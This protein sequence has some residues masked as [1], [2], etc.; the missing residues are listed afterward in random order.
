MA[1]SGCMEDVTRCMRGE[2]PRR[3]PVFCCTEEADVRLSGEVYERYCS[4]AETM[5]R[6]Q[7]EAIKRF[8]LDW[9]WLQVDDCI[10]YEVLGVGVVGQGNILRATKDYLP[11]SRETLNRLKKIDFHKD[12]RCPVLLNAIRRV[13]DEFGDDVCVVGRTEAPLSS[14]S[15]L[16]GITETMMLLITD[17]Q[18]VKD[19]MEYFVDLQIG[20]GLAQFEAGADALWFGDC[21]ASSHLI[22]LNHYQEFAADPLKKV[23]EEYAKTGKFTILH[24]SE[25]SPEY[26]NVMAD[27]SCSAVSVGPGAPLAECYDVIAGRAC[28]VGNVDPIEVLYRGTP[29]DVRKQTAEIIETVSRRGG[30]IINSGEMVPRDTPEENVHAMVQTARELWAQA[31]SG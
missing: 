10:I 26:V 16:Y 24:A 5:A 30:H 21:N 15:L 22:S 18:L 13:K 9:A 14:V 7:I 20:F 3:L 4:D 23:A 25:E 6:V 19:T 29:E 28:L 12:G 11:A 31:Q 8:D 2:T 27:L 1:Y 17:P